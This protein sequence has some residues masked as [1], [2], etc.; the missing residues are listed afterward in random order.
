MTDVP[1]P[2]FIADAMLGKLVKWL[3]VMGIDVAY[4]PAV[5]H[6]QLLR[7]REEEGRI[8][9]TRDRRLTSWPKRAGSSGYLFIE[10]DYYHEQVRQV[11]RMCALQQAIQVF[12]RC[13]RC[14]TLLQTVTKET[15]MRRVPPYIAAT[16]TTFK[17]CVACDR[18]Y[19]AGTHRNNML[20]QLQ[21]MLG[22]A[23]ALPTDDLP[24][25]SQACHRQV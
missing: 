4:D 11:V 17:H 24:H 5:A 22:E 15:A 9:L 13:L 2:R 3:R 16:Q 8:L 25:Q 1:A 14:N 20:R 12:S 23:L 10:S 7:S 18:L 6:D 21:A 19:W